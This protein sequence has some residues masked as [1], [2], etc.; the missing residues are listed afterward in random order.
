MG[1]ADYLLIL[2][3]RQSI[4]KIGNLAAKA[5]PSGDRK[6][7]PGEEAVIIAGGQ[8]LTSKPVQVS[9]FTGADA[10]IASPDSNESS[11]GGNSSDYYSDGDDTMSDS[12]GG[13][14]DGQVGFAGMMDSVKQKMVNRIMAEFLA[15]FGADKGR[16]R[17]YNPVECPATSTPNTF[18]MGWNGPGPSNPRNAGK[19]PN[20]RGSDAS[21]NGGDDRPKRP[22][23][24]T[25]PTTSF[26][27]RL[28]F[29]CPYFKR[30]A[31]KHQKWR[32][33]AAPGWNSVRRVK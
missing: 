7:S 4:M 29:A 15:M 21:N 2:L 33:C 9:K 20:R 1:R 23:V 14:R 12:E 30:N 19:F 18:L 28:R 27:T 17:P 32:S 31:G 26:E 3:L 8:H 16:T 22:A 10:A 13:D 24:D 11:Q 5:D 25:P 6:S